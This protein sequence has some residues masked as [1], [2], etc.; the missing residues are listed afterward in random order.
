M[1]IQ[2]TALRLASLVVLSTFGL[3]GQS[4][5]TAQVRG[6]ISDASGAGI[7]GAKVSVVE[8]DRNVP[9]VATT[10]EAG[11][12]VAA[13]LPPGNYRINVEAQ[14]FKQANRSVFP[15]SVQQQ[16]TIDFTMQVGDI[17]TSV[18]VESQAPLL[19]TTIATLG[20]VIENRYMMALPNI[21][22]NPLALL[23]LTPGVVGA[24]GTINPTN[25]NFVA[26][27]ARNAQEEM[28]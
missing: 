7:P 14:G 27:G 24:A 2:G 18:S 25:T 22:R 12:Y 9:H 26:G 1:S 11:R 28:N 13:G 5:F 4:S 21:G 3:W 6:V 19:N 20:Q 15:L 8:A 23:N 10:D 16:A 17:S